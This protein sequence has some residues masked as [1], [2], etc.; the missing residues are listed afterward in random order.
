M[1]STGILEPEDIAGSMLAFGFD[2]V[3]LKD[4]HARRVVAEWNIPN[5]VLF[6]RNLRDPRQV[7][8]LTRSIDEH[9]RSRGLSGALIMV[10]Q[11][12]GM[13][14]RM[15]RYTTPMPGNMA[16]G[17]I[18][19]ESE[20]RQA[21]EIIGR[22]LAA[23]GINLDLV[24]VLDVLEEPES[25]VVGER[26]FGE[27]PELVSKLG[28]A[29][30]EGLHSSGVGATAKHFPG[31]GST[32]ID[33]HYDLPRVRLSASELEKHI[34]PF[35]Y[36]VLRG[37][38]AVMLGHIL[39]DAVDPKVPA[40]LSARAVNMVRGMGFNGLIVSDCME[41]KAVASRYTPEQIVDLALK[42]GLDIIM[43]S[44]TLRVQKRAYDRMLK[45]VLRGDVDEDRLKAS[46]TR[47]EML[48]KRLRIKPSSKPEEIVGSKRH[49]EKCIEQACRAL[50][51]IK[52][53]SELGNSPSKPLITYPSRLDAPSPV[54]GA[55]GVI[56]A[57]SI[58]RESGIRAECIGLGAGKPEPD[59]IIALFYSARD[60]PGLPPRGW[61]LV[62]LGNP[63]W[64]RRVDL[65]GYK[66]VVAAYS[67]RYCSLK[68][69]FNLIKRR[70]RPK[71]RLPVTLSKKLP[72]G[73]TCFN[74]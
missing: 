2:G 5:I 65:S 33:S 49:I 21:G 8:I 39:V 68:A 19:L 61:M 25:S 62:S 31:H 72:S 69:L 29:F 3:S 50:T 27:N 18:G 22:E 17:A 35:R 26:S 46:I 53:C 41:M 37:V 48:A 7:S 40:S 6:N 66:V 28:A 70:C 63:V 52:G 11:E 47:R 60:L 30:I 23:M 55:G 32:I 14:L 38:D 13:V 44:H 67:Y 1:R 59:R 4:D 58:A 71:G 56:S 15:P 9:V 36:A 51:V 43:F 10:D 64:L 16:L 45:L 34:A 73:H 57:C 74:D 12:G 20:A 24:P 54:A 42:A